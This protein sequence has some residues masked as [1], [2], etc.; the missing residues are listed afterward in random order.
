MID[1]SL[2]DITPV[3]LSQ[4]GRVL[5]SSA[6]W[7]ENGLFLLQFLVFAAIAFA[8]AILGGVL[9]TR[10]LFPGN[11]ALSF[12]PVLVGL[13][14]TAGFG[15]VLGGWM[16]R[17]PWSADYMFHKAQSELSQRTEAIVDPNNPE[18]IYVEVIPRRNWGQISLQNA[19][20]VGFLFLD[21]EGRQM[22]LEGDN[23]RYRIP[24]QALVSCD[25]ELMNPS[26]ADDERATPVGLVIIKVRD[27][28]GEREIPLRPVRTVAGDA[29]GGN[30][31]ARAHELNRRLL[32]AFPEALLEITSAAGA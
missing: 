26:A 17:K 4:R 21:A 2:A 24:V 8:P 14:L 22:L 3:P 6:K 1:D 12:A 15:W 7:M 10:R 28:M 25:V 18:A 11:Q 30:Y 19:D 23:K 27:R 16:M 32:G 29:L 13:A 5:T 20:D 31:M 9:A